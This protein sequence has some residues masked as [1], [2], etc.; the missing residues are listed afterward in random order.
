MNDP[1][2]QSGVT[3]RPH[4]HGVMSA[5]DT[6][7]VDALMQ[8]I[9]SATSASE[10]PHP[11]VTTLANALFVDSNGTPFDQVSVALNGIEMPRY[12]LGYYSTAGQPVPPYP[13]ALLW[14]VPLLFGA[15]F[16]Y[17][18]TLAAPMIVTG[19]PA[20]GDTISKASGATISYRGSSG[21]ELFV[22]VLA[23]AL[24]GV[25]GRPVD[26]GFV[27]DVQ[28]DNGVVSLHPA[29]LRSLPPDRWYWVVFQHQS[30][31]VVTH[32]DRRIGLNSSYDT[33]IWF[34]L[35]P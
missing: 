21:G 4:D 8:Y 16:A 3:L 19:G 33:A 24:N 1:L 17:N 25:N 10:S 15:D 27:Y 28:P 34:Y 9:V 7:A 32:R 30:Y 35:A 18:D 23:H 26:I 13:H 20:V 5:T 2:G 22:R 12:Q 31:R 6:G 14:R 11:E 29:L